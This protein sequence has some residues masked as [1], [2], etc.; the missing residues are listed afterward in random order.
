MPTYNVMKAPLHARQLVQPTAEG[1]HKPQDTL[2]AVAG[3]IGMVLGLP[4]RLENMLNQG[5][6]NLTNGISQALPSFPAATIGSLTL[7]LPHAHT[8]HPPSGPPPIPPTPLPPLGAVLLGTSVSVLINGI[9]AARSGDLG[10]NPTCVGLPP[11][12][13]IFTGSSKVFISGKRAAR[14]LDITFH[15]KNSAGGAAGAAGGAMAAVGAVANV[16]GKVAQAAGVAADV[17]D[18][19]EGDV[20]AAARLGMMAAQAA[21]DAVAKAASAAMGKDPCVPPGTMGAVLLGAPN[22]LIGGFP[23]PTWGNIAKG[24][25]KLLKGLKNRKKTAPPAASGKPPC[26]CPKS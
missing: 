26:G 16:A 1:E 18:A 12:F 4:G 17:M 22:V 3:G 8:L 7:G 19:V 14:M 6:A 21:A 2:R 25:M 5:F 9:P 10:F 11:M 20:G 15:C 23:M 24:F 13:E